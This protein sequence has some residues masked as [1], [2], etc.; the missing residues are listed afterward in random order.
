MNEIVFFFFF[1]KHMDHTCKTPIGAGAQ[2]D[3][4]NLQ[5]SKN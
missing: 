3:Q 5:T 1:D 2:E 4:N